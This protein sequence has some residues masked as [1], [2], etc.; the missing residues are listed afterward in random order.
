M[1]Q[2][3]IRGLVVVKDGD[4]YC[5]RNV[6]GLVLARGSR[7]KMFRIRHLMEALDREI[8]RRRQGRGTVVN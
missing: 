8:Y 6:H 2:R 5:V 1:F 7:E 4:A 3:P